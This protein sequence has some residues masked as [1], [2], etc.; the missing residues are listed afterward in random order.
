VRRPRRGRAAPRAA[1][2]GS[3][4]A[5]SS[6]LL[7]MFRC[8]LIGTYPSSGLL[9][10]SGLANESDV[11]V[12]CQLAPSG[13]ALVWQASGPLSQSG[14]RSFARASAFPN[15]DSLFFGPAS[16]TTASEKPDDRV[17]R[18]GEDEIRCCCGSRS[19]LDLAASRFHGDGLIT[20]ADLRDESRTARFDPSEDDLDRAGQPLA[21]EGV[22]FFSSAHES[23][24]ADQARGG[25]W[26]APPKT[27]RARG[28]GRQ[29]ATGR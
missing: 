11:V 2:V 21:L 3:C 14:R 29:T 9:S 8:A 4:G 24:P 18:S 23:V 26:L 25:L 10:Q 19:E 28:A 27:E 1:L 22:V 7:P 6:G 5:A 13:Q 15:A 16:V 17:G 20:G 12:N